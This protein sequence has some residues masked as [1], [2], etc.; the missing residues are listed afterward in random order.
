MLDYQ[1]HILFAHF[2]PLFTTNNQS[3]HRTTAPSKYQ[4]PNNQ[5]GKKLSGSKGAVTEPPPSNVLTGG[6]ATTHNGKK[7]P[8]RGGD[9]RNAPSKYATVGLDYSRQVLIHHTVRGFQFTFQW[10][11]YI[12]QYSVF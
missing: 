6:S 3:K 4:P 9:R 7:F 11:M 8:L 2:L 12:N 10:L 5:Y 1:W